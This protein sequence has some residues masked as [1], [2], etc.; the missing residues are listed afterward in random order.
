MFKQLVGE[1]R[2]DGELF[3]RYLSEFNEDDKIEIIQETKNFQMYC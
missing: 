3:E 2:I 1:A